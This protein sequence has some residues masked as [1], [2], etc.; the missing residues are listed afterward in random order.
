M[1]S[2]TE[3]SQLLWKKIG[4]FSSIADLSHK[5]E[6]R[7]FFPEGLQTLGLGRAYKV[8]AEIP[9]KGLG[10]KMGPE[11]QMVHF[12]QGCICDWNLTIDLRS[13]ETESCTSG[14]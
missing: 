10:W 6:K 13:S 5:A 9:D 2:L 12:L 14:F 11:T 1:Q 8:D 7:F 3:T 4:A